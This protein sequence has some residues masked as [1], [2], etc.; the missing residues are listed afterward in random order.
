MLWRLHLRP[1]PKNGKTHNDV[2]KY[3]IDNHIAGIGWPVP[4]NPQNPVEYEHAAMST[5]G[6]HVA[7]IP[8]AKSPSK[9][10]FI[11]AR[12]KNGRYYL[13]LIK[14]DWFYS[15]DAV[16]VDLDIPNQR[17]CDWVEIGNE[18][19][20]PG[21]I[22]AC[23]RPAKTFQPVRDRLMEEFS[24][25]I[26]TNRGQARSD[27]TVFDKSGMTKSAF[28]KLIGADDCE[29]VVGL[30]LQK[31]KSYCLIPSSCKQNTIGYEF[32]MKHADTG[33]SAVA[34]VKQGHVSLDDRLND[35]ADHIYLFSTD[36]IV[37]SISDKIT[38]LT[39]DELFDF[40]LLNRMLLPKRIEYWFSIF[41]K[42]SE[43]KD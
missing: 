6:K 23:F 42:V 11:W 33:Q 35:S 20:V 24:T 14:G 4:G 8:F 34:Q 26:Y 15:Y 39:V 13:G 17:L 29:D 31:V 18:E 43:F 28:F 21:K 40:V 9:G 27:A 38:V 19:Y 7:S 1:S 25:W 36:G 30:Y 10:D 5:Y 2:V 3:C 16:H 12:D 22:V 32:V 37:N 41:Q